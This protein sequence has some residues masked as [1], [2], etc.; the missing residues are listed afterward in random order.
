VKMDKRRLDRIWDFV[1]E[2]PG[3]PVFRRDPKQVAKNKKIGKAVRKAW[4]RRKKAKSKK[5]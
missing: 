2:N 3:T 5:Q 1:Q 4:A